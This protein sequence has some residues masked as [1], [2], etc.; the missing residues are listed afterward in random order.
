V[1]DFN[2]DGKPDIAVAN[3]NLGTVSV[4]LNISIARGIDFA[5]QRSA[6][7]MT[8]SWPLPSTAFVLESTSNL[9]STNWQPAVEVLR[10][11][12]DRLEIIAPLNQPQRFF[13]L[14]KP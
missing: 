11:N 2:G 6:S 5:I 14:R 9:G 7:A 13:R 10:T 12:N 4:L 8:F 1:G 3:L